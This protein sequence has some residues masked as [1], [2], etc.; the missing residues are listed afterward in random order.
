MKEILISSKSKSEEGLREPTSGG[1]REQKS[2][3]LRE[4][5]SGGLREKKNGGVRGQK[6]GGLR[7]QTRGVLREQ[8]RKGLREQKRKGLR[9]HKNGGLR[10]NNNGE[11]LRKNCG[12]EGLKEKDQA[13]ECTLCSKL[14]KL[15][16]QLGRHQQICKAEKIS[17]LYCDKCGAQFKSK[18]TL[19]FHEQKC[20]RNALTEHRESAHKKTSCDFCDYFG[21]K[22]NIKR[23]VKSVHKGLTPGIFARF[24]DQKKEQ[25]FKCLA[26]EK[27]FFDKSTLNRHRQMY[28]YY[29]NVCCKSFRNKKAFREH[30]HKEE[31]T[32]EVLSIEAQLGEI[33]VEEEEQFVAK[34]KCVNWNPKLEEVKEFIDSKY[35]INE[36]KLREIYDMF[37]ATEN[38]LMLLMNRNQ[39]VKLIDVKQYYERNV[40][41][42]FEVN[43]F[44]AML[45]INHDAYTIELYKKEIH[46]EMKESD[47]NITPSILVERNQLMKNRLDEYFNN[48]HLYVDI[49]EFPEPPRSSYKTAKEVLKANILKFS[50]SD[51]DET[52]MENVTRKMTF[53]EMLERVKKK[54]EKKKKREAN[55]NKINWQAQRLPGFAR[56][57]NRIFVTEKKSVLRIEQLLAKLKFA[58]VGNAI[59]DLNCLIK[60]SHGWLENVMGCIRRDS[61]LDINKICDLL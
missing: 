4:Q 14:F 49:F 38:I 57:V 23:H 42:D 34:R 43:K 27:V 37:K 53:P 18:K 13:I 45:A 31:T 35:K 26:C 16:S 19:N 21:H 51:S 12:S 29:C 52:D 32:E 56:L 2:G 22:R 6:S 59:S 47:E 50:D 55:F 10:E 41:K 61:S 36:Q 25:K 20:H 54:E 1:L 3:G 15:E 24:Q 30:S 11:E 58:Q 9:E 17:W 5:K 40:K 60:K 33:Q 44:K 48:N 39:A 46:I 8:K 7:E 28:C